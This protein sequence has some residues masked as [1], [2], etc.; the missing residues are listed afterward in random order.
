MSELDILI[1]ENDIEKPKYICYNHFVI[2]IHPEEDL[3]MKVPVSLIIDDPAPVI[4]VYHE[5]SDPP[6][7][8]DGR[9]LITHFPNEL[10][11]R[12]CD[13]VEKR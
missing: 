9:P 4:S 2:I 11:D 3:K 5:H 7:T 10:L 13:V 8:K 12:F 6:T 1:I